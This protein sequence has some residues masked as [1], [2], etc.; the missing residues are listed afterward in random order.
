MLLQI[1]QI[2]SY[3]SD[4][5]TLYSDMSI[6]RGNGAK[7]TPKLSQYYFSDIIVWHLSEKLFQEH[8]DRCCSLIKLLCIYFSYFNLLSHRQTVLKKIFFSK[9]YA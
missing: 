3:K 5:A 6:M 9:N 4:Y 8:H 7:V 2:C 1:T